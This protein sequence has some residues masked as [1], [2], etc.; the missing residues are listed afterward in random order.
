M[1]VVGEYLGTT[2]VSF[3]DF[4]TGSTTV[5]VYLEEKPKLDS[6][7]LR[8]LG[9]ALKGRT[10]GRGAGRTGIFSLQR[11][12]K[13]D[14]AESW[15]EHFKPIQIGSNLLIKPGWSGKRAKKGQKV[16]V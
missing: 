12:R 9:V 14:W 4:E 5:S 10:G 1:E 11:V 13:R 16:V 8:A 15:K 6:P 3:N 2:A 7:K